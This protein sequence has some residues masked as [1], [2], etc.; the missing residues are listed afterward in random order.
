MNTSDLTVGSHLEDPVM[1]LHHH[2]KEHLICVR[3]TRVGGGGYSK[4]IY[5]ESLRP[6][7][8]QEVLLSFFFHVARNKLNETYK[9]RLLASAQ[10]KVPFYDYFAECEIG[11]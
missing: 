7:V 10:F 9:L 8:K 6:E 3:H 5:T 11:V 2:Y 1:I 4:N